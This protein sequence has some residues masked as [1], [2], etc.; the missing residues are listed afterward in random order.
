MPCHWISLFVTVS[1]EDEAADVHAAGRDQV[2][3]HLRRDPAVHATRR[4]R[5][6][7][8]PHRP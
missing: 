2:G 5:G 6:R 7:G 8:I 3:D 4:K 1:G